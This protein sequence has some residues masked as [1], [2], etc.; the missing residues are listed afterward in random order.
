MN[1]IK[2]GKLKNIKLFKAQIIYKLLFVF[3]SN[4]LYKYLLKIFYISYQYFKLCNILTKNF[5]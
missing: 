3:N 2:L 5:K 4:S 1:G